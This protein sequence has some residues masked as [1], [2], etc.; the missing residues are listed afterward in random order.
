MAQG[1]MTYNVRYGTSSPVVIH[2]DDDAGHDG[3]VA[4]GLLCRVPDGYGSAPHPTTRTFDVV[5]EGRASIARVSTEQTGSRL[6]GR[7]AV[8]RVDDQYGAPLGRITYRSGRALRGA[9]A[10]WT[11][12][13]VTGRRVS[14]FRGRLFWWALWW[15]VGL[16]VSLVCL[17][18]SLLGE[19]DGAFG[20]PRRVIWRDSSRR[21]HLVF[22]GIEDEYRVLDGSWDP[23]LV[24]ALLGLHQSYDPSEGSGA[25]GW[26]VRP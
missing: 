15:P 18:L 20:K 21:A 16:P 10:R 3:H 5:G 1:R 24:A 17:I 23:R 19:G 8:Y 14:G 22:R 7:P 25:H 11:V 13:T 2:H 4:I 6:S 12:E 9:R 26:Y